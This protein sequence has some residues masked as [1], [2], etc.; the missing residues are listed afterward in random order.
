MNKVILA[1]AILVTTSTAH[2][3]TQ[4]T[5]DISVSGS[6][7]AANTCTISVDGG[8]TLDA[9]SHNTVDLVSTGDRIS[10]FK[11]FNATVGCTFPTAIAVKYTSSLPPQPD[12][13]YRLGAYQTNSGKVAAHLYAAIGGSNAPTAG[14]VDQAF[15][16]IGDQ[17]LST[18]STSSTLT[19]AA[20]GTPISGVVGDSRNIYTVID[21]NN[22]PVAATA[23]VLPFKLGVWS[24]D[25]SSGWLD[26]IAGSSFSLSST[27][28]LE[29]H[30]I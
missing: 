19:P 11:E 28:T 24:D 17:D 27:V 26:D 18:I 14:G 7:N 8:G 23:F 21:A 1:T 15:A 29:L 5:A 22:N 6:I 25:T 10:E 2:A 30:S 13:S 3:Q 4:D 16:A 12:K 20:D 9:G